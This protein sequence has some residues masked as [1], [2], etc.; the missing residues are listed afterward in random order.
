LKPSEL[1]PGIAGSATDRRRS[2]D[3]GDL[4]GRTAKAAWFPS[5]APADAIAARLRAILHGYEPRHIVGSS[6]L[7][8]KVQKVLG[9]QTSSIHGNLE[10]A[11]RR[12]QVN[13]QDARERLGRPWA[14][15]PG[16]IS[17]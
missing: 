12:M 15:G 13:Q 10:S 2:S 7:K 4:K 8:V 3:E 16:Q 6:I 1:R 11:A 9:R 5:V 14:G 17:F